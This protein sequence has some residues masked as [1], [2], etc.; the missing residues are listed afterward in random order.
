[1][2]RNPLSRRSG[3]IETK[4]PTLLSSLEADRLGH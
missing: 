1:V 2:L 4:V 3:F